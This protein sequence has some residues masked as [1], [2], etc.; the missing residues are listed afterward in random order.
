VDKDGQLSVLFKD[1]D[2]KTKIINQATEGLGRLAA[3]EYSR[4]LFKKSHLDIL[5]NI[6]LSIYYNFTSS[7]FF[8]LTI[9]TK[10]NI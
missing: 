10:H 4:R 9:G 3:G 5:R 6:T 8:H 1:G 2:W 7:V